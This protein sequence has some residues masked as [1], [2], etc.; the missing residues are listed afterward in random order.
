MYKKIRYYLF[1]KS[2]LMI[3]MNKLMLINERIS[4]ILINNISFFYVINWNIF[5]SKQLKF[6]WYILLL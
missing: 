1:K 5:S 4:I 6:D 2:Y 3:A